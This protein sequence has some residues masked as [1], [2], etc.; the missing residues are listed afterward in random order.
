MNT[1]DHGQDLDMDKRIILKLLE[2]TGLECVHCIYL[3][4]ERDRLLFLMKS[5]VK[6]WVPQKEENFL[7]T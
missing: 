4:Q 6:L 7:I 5:V 2:E 3:A 1:S